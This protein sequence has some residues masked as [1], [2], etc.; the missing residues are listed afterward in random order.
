M[1][2]IPK[3]ELEE[4]GTPLKLKWKNK[5]TLETIS[6]GHGISVTHYRLPQLMLA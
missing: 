1:L 4:L 5:C 6:Y 3:F 2:I